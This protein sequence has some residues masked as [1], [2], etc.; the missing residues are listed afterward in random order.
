LLE[1]ENLPEA[2]IDLCQNPKRRTEMGMQAK[3][4]MEQNK[5]ALE[6]TLQM[7]KRFL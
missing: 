3:M 5:D 4:V 6:K 1:K 2:V 7:I